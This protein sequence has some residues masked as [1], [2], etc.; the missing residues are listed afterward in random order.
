MPATASLAV[1]PPEAQEEATAAPEQKRKTAMPPQED[2]EE[3]TGLRIAN[4]CLPAENWSQMIRGNNKRVVPFTR[5]S[6]L[7]IRKQTCDRIVIGVLYERTTGHRLA[8]GEAYDC[9]ALTDLAEPRPRHFMLHLRWQAYNH[10]R[11][12]QAVASARRGSIFAVMNPAIVDE[13]TDNGNPVARVEKP[14]QILKLGTCPSLGTC[15]MKGCRLPCNADAHHRIC[16]MHMT[17]AWARKESRMVADGGSSTSIAFLREQ[18]SGKAKPVARPLASAQDEQAEAEANRKE[19]SAALTKQAKDAVALRLDDRRFDNCKAKDEYIKS[20]CAGK[21]AE[22]HASSRVPVLGRGL[23]GPGESELDLELD[24][25]ERQK[26]ERMIER[27]AEREEQGIPDT[28]A[29]PAKRSRPGNPPAKSARAADS[30]LS[31]VATLEPK[32]EPKKALGELLEALNSRRIAR[33][34][35]VTQSAGSR[36]AP[37]SPR[38]PRGSRPAPASPRQAVVEAGGA[39]DPLQP[40]SVPA[41]GDLLSRAEALLA[42]FQAAAVAG[43]VAGAGRVMA[44]LAVAEKLPASVLKEGAGAQLYDA[45]GRLALKH[46]RADVKRLA[47]RTRRQWRCDSYA[48]AS[49]A[50]AEAPAAAEVASAQEQPGCAAVPSREEEATAGDPADTVVSTAGNDQE[51]LAPLQ[52]ATREYG[53]K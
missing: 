25:G 21:R 44:A 19:D 48:A 29:P 9:W 15:D 10:W 5:L 42:E 13:G 35:G 1:A 12:G 17:M 30:R 23:K 38:P 26:A 27:R 34:A 43:D 49:E 20:I 45:V 4:R 14:L 11:T 52:E 31:G 51:V 50:R 7:R 16:Q 53:D 8:N 22:A 36:A 18:R 28:S 3:F 6:E 2:R 39:I 41:Q 47:I 46:S 32:P 40:P 37:S 24:W 33:R